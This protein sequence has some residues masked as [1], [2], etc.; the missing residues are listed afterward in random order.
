MYRYEVSNSITHNERTIYGLLDWLGDVGGL[1]EMLYLLFKYVAMGWITSMYSDFFMVRNLFSFQSKVT[2]EKEPFKTAFR[3]VLCEK[4]RRRKS[5]EHRL[6]LK[7]ADK[8]GLELDIVQ[9]LRRA[10]RFK[11]LVKLILTK[12]Q[13]ITLNESKR[14]TLHTTSSSPEDNLKQLKKEIPTAITQ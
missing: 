6:L 4:M 1:L 9:V 14:F 5:R 12:A 10:F 3:T 11:D 13:R 8:I 2:S 7:G